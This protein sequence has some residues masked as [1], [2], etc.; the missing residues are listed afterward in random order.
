MTNKRDTTET[1]SSD[2]AVQVNKDNEMTPPVSVPP[3]ALLIHS[4]LAQLDTKSDLI[5]LQIACDKAKQT[6]PNAQSIE[7][8][9]YI[10]QQT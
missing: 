5:E 4:L 9:R 1:S 8:T 6:L 2:E 7:Q 3:P 10:L